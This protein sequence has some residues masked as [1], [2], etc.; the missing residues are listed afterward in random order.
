MEIK[1]VRNV[2]WVCR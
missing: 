1:Q 2:R